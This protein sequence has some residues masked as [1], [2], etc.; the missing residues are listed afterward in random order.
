[1]QYPRSSP[2]PAVNSS[3]GFSV[4]HTTPARLAVL[5][6]LALGSTTAGVA[7]SAAAG[8]DPAK[9]VGIAKQRTLHKDA[10]SFTNPVTQAKG[11]RQAWFVQFAGQG[12]ADAAQRAGG[13]AR[14][15]AAARSR[16][17]Q[18]RSVSARVLTAARAADSK[19]SSLFTVSNAIP[20]AGMMLDTAAVKAVVGNPNVVKVSRIVPKTAENSNV[21]QL[22][23][24]L[25]TWKFSG[26]I[27]GGVTVG[28]IDTGLDYTHADFGGRGTA[29]AYDAAHAQE[30]SPTWRQGLP[31]KGQKK[32]VGGYDFA[33][34]DYQAD[35]NS[36]AYQPIPHP[37]NNPLDCNGHGTHVAGTAA[38]YGVTAGGKTLKPK[39]LTKLTGKKLQ[40][41]IVGPGM[42]PG[43]SIFALR[44]F[45]CEGSTDV[46]IPALDRALD[47][48]G[49][50]FFDDHLDIVN[51][52]L[53]SD[54]G[55]VDDPENAVVDELTR[56]GVL[57]VISMG[58]NG[59][60]TDTGGSPGNAVSSLAAA[61]SVDSYQ[62]RD[63]LKVNGPAGVA[64][65]S[66]GQFSIAYD[67]P[68]NGPTHAPVTGTV[69]ALSEPG[70][71]DGCDPLSPADAAAVAGKVAWL[72]WDSNDAT[73]ECGSAGRSANVRAAGAIGAVFTGDV[74]PFAA[75]ITGDAVIPVFQLTKD[76][77]AK[78][79]P[80]V[81]TG[82]LNVT[83]DGGLAHTVPT[84][85]NALTDTIS[86]FTSR[87][88]HGSIGVVKPDVAAVG[89]TVASAGVGTGN[90]V[91]V[92]SGTSMA[93]PTTTGVAALVK[94]AHPKWSPLKVKTAIMNTARHDLFKGQG[95]TGPRYAPA[96]VGA[97]R[98][99]AAG[100]V[101]TKLLAYVSGANN[102]VSASFGV[103]E[104]PING[105]T[106]TRTRQLT[107]RNLGK[108][109]AKVSVSYEAINNQPGVSYSVSP[110]KV[111]IKSKR[112]KKVTVTMT[113]NPTALRRTIDPT[114]NAIQDNVFYADTEPRQFVPDASGRLLVKPKGKAPNRVP[115]YGSAKPTSKT[116]A[117]LSG[118]NLVLAGNGVATGGTS[119]ADYNSIVSVLQLGETSPQLP[120][121][122]N[123]E[124]D[125]GCV[126]GPTDRSM[127][128]QYVGAGS[129]NDTDVTDG[130]I[131][132]GIST[133]GDW[134]SIG[135]SVIPFVDYSIGPDDFETYVQII[136]GTDLLYAWTVDLN[137][138]TLV[139]LQP[140]NFLFAD[141]DSN[142]FDTNVITFGAFKANLGVAGT[143]SLPITYQAGT[144]GP[145][146]FLDQTGVISYD[147]GTPTLGTGAELFDDQ[148]GRSIALT[149]SG[150]A[151]ALVLHLHGAKGARAEVV[152]RP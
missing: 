67:W 75:G 11:A 71:D 119:S 1:V 93:A 73:R 132:F 23:K 101:K 42:A 49:D 15:A 138:N 91:L 61:S 125:D 14:G 105:G 32:V 151:Q 9:P 86:G 28:V 106:V 136:D 123:G 88:P 129:T 104:A 58:N 115:V 146:S 17:A 69:V 37:D 41:M 6:V 46:V 45:G 77:T 140:V 89:D 56:H 63:G 130:T 3:K 133:Y 148:G 12:A 118:S 66:P 5:T 31:K 38:G 21:V 18:V 70:N 19:A 47:P 124:P 68:N 79:A 99:D 134:S 87:G 82:T 10:R 110:S 24:A 96:R 117:S 100:A 92:E 109:T 84:Y 53:G 147:A 95:R 62:L 98:I 64:G 29:A 112:K 111:S 59:D 44:V 25:K 33:G 36:P 57:S 43:A 113:V 149:G 145:F 108:K 150:P 65:I 50:G 4:K 131:Y 135:T 34:D 39:K 27:G 54:Y 121:C 78:L 122:T 103:V 143:G 152:N 48:N 30:T 13:S 81:P 128:L 35:P 52:S 60:L 2:R 40:K 7:A 76:A 85:N 94:A 120:A 141:T 51:M 102:P 127:D 8:P 126:A 20:G 142:V 26:N 97:G 137:A 55:P 144:V 22:V 80:A 83:F 74:E 114:M 116:T 90:D 72:T 16:A 139:D 107:I